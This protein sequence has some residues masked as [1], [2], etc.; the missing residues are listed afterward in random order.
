M[1]TLPEAMVTAPDRH[2]KIRVFVRFLIKTVGNECARVHAFGHVYRV[3][4]MID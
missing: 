3:K 2:N 4:Q 1:L